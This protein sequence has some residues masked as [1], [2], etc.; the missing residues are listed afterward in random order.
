MG[1]AIKRTVPRGGRQSVIWLWYMRLDNLPERLAGGEGADHANIRRRSGPD[2]R[3]GESA[4][5]EA[6]GYP[7]G[8]AKVQIPI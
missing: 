5:S 3:E 7:L 2:V 6:A 4:L 8:W 1:S